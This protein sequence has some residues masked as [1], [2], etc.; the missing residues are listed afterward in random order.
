MGMPALPRHLH[1]GDQPDRP[2]LRLLA[3]VCEE[4]G[5]EGDPAPR[6]EGDPVLCRG[7]HALAEAGDGVLYWLP[8]GHLEADGTVLL[9]GTVRCAICDG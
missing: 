4:C 6:A 1:D 9:D 5:L 8:C 7:C 2:R 3:L